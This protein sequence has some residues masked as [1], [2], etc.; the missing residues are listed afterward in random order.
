MQKDSGKELGQQDELGTLRERIGELEALNARL[1]NSQEE[2]RKLALAMKHSS[3]LVNMSTLDGM[4]TY[5]NRAGGE[6]LGIDPERVI[7]TNIMEVIPEH[8]TGLVE[9]ELLPA[10]MRGDTWEGDLQYRNLKTG[11]LTDVHAVTFTV[12]DPNT[13][14]PQFLA[15][16]SQDI[17]ERKRA[18]ESLRNSE[19]RLRVL[20]ERAPDAYYLCDYKGC[21]IDGNEAAEEITGF[22]REELIGKSFLKLKLLSAKDIA[23]AAAQLARSALG[24]ATGPDEFA[25]NRKDGSQVPV[26]IRTHPVK[27]QGQSLLLG[28]ARDITQRKTAEDALREGEE[29]VQA[30]VETSRDWIWSLDREGRHTYSNPA[31]ERILGYKPADLIG[32]S[33]L[34]LMHPEDKDDVEAWLPQW[35]QE[36][37][38][39]HNLVLR[40]RHKDGR[41][42]WLESNAA[43]IFDA[44][45]ELVGF[46]GVDRDITDRREAEQALMAGEE[47]Y[48]LLFENMMNGFALHEI[49]LS[50]E[51]KPVDYE[52][53]EVNSAFERL[54]GLRSEDLIGNRV[55][56]VLPGIEKDPA[57]W[58]GKYG[59]VALS[60]R[61]ARFEQYAEP[62]GKWFSIL[63]FSPGKEQFATIFEDVTERKQAEEETRQKVAELAAINEIG[64]AVGANIG[65]DAVLM[66]IYQQVSTL[67]DAPDFRIRLFDPESNTLRSAFK[68]KNGQRQAPGQERAC[69]QGRSEFVVRTGKPL[70]LRNMT[71]EKYQDMGIITQSPVPSFAGVPMVSSGTV[72]GVLS[73]R[74]WERGDA[75]DEKHLAVLTAVAS[76]AA[77]SIE[78]ARLFEQAQQEIADRIRAEEEKLTMEAQLRQSQKLESIG[79]LASGVAHE[80]N[81]PLTGVINYAELLK[82]RV[83]DDERAA[84]YAE[85]IIEEGNRIA[86]IV[87]N[88]LSFAR[89]D[90]AKY[91]PA[92][93]FDIV[94]DSLSLLHASLLKNQIEVAVNVSEDLPE[95]SCRSQQIQQVLVNLI[96]NAQASLNERYPE[97][98]EDKF[99]SI[100]AEVS[101]DDN[102]WLRITV[103]DHGIGIPE[104]VQNRIFDPFFTSKSRDQGT[105]LGLAVSHGIVTEHQGN[106]SLESSEGEYTRFHVDLPLQQR[107]SLSVEP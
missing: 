98:D 35:I 78:N 11:E 81:N 27:I 33:S 10:L 1:R 7:A 85:A 6:I 36:E 75:L 88:L 16:I 39:W 102:A 18:E 51:G 69:G 66:T 47:K 53:L 96:T 97:Y 105:G 70:L 29:A 14:E 61:E 79:T 28:I 71:P 40:W 74:N 22:S 107:E 73:V 26:E 37:T 48:R 95:V 3:E 103:E 64:L 82:D 50:E 46:R 17:T 59:R 62:L 43:P 57:D 65:L 41:W 15:N 90:E 99:L 83:A 38:G 89:Q 32:R 80:V 19:E 56:D 5:L 94:T 44:G 93:I 106:I 12:K 4:M 9:D 54:T 55:I 68:M 92:R 76:Q 42:R 13:G 31:V 60:G 24:K 49:I 72:V 101:G 23:R 45:G 86:G 34:E 77:A 8:L 87:K 20:F 63:A 25:L 67:I 2:E 52:F 84:E 100:S 30:I 104:E 21:F 91:S 58:I